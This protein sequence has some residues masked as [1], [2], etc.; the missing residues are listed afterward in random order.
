MHCL[1][2]NIHFIINYVNCKQLTTFKLNC[3]YCISIDLYTKKIPGKWQQ[4][5]K[6]TQKTNMGTEEMGKSHVTCGNVAKGCYLTAEEI[7]TDRMK[8]RRSHPPALH[9]QP[10]VS[11]GDTPL[12]LERW[13]RQLAE[14]GS[15]RRW[16]VD[17]PPPGLSVCCRTAGVFSLAGAGC[18][19]YILYSHFYIHKHM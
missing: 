15:V 5:K 12:I 13:E 11:E 9:R 4:S 16:R 10:L 18:Y 6:N 7:P 19:T 2:T 14:R 8:R 17:I 3:V 1:H